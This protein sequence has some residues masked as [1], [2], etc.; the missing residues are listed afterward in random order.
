[1]IVKLRCARFKKCDRPCESY[2]PIR[3]PDGNIL[4]AEQRLRFKES[5]RNRTAKQHFRQIMHD[6][7]ERQKATKA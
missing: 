1:M 5:L 3:D 6:E 2:A 4:T 7:L